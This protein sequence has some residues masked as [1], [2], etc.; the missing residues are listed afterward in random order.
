MKINSTQIIYSEHDYDEC[1]EFIDGS[2]RVPEGDAVGFLIRLFPD[3]KT[4]TKL[5]LFQ[6]ICYCQNDH[7]YWNNLD[8]E[9][10]V[11]RLVLP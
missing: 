6:D 10:D 2:G 11:D 4:P 1:F 7:T 5:V 9:N 8:L 3:D